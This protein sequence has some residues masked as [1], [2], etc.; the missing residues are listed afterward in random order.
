MSEKSLKE[1]QR[2][3][4][5]SHFIDAAHEIIE[6]EGIEE[7]T[8]RKVADVAGYN[9]GTLY[10]YFKN[11]DHL[12][13]FAGVKYLK[14]YYAVLDDY[15]KEADNAEVRYIK[16]WQLFCK[17][18]FERPKIWKAI[19]FLTPNEDVREIFDE[20]F[21]IYPGDFGIHS[22]DLI[23]MLNAPDIFDRSRQ[24]LAPVAEEG[25]IPKECVDELNEMTV[26][27]YRGILERLI[28]SHDE[29]DKKVELEKFV[30]FVKIGLNAFRL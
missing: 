21:E 14:D 10:N 17:Y 20:Y 16:I 29:L 12:I 22:D 13:G 27:V 19:F 30:N 11:L 18:S 28:T 4:T 15:I 24:C 1:R 25:I 8:V 7:I 5:M 2:L 26:L 23:T 6:N 3:R 9:I